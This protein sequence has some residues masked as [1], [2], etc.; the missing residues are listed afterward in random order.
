MATKVNWCAF[1][2]STYMY[3]A[4]P[5]TAMRIPNNVMEYNYVYTYV[6]MYFLIIFTYMYVNYMYLVLGNQ[7]IKVSLIFY[8]LTWH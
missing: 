7:Y 3:F 8:I 5:M 4:N 2:D 1:L 6:H